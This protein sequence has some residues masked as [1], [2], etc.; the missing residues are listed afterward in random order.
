MPF[1]W[2]LCQIDNNI[3]VTHTVLSEHNSIQLTMHFTESTKINTYDCLYVH[4][5]MTTLANN[6]AQ[7]E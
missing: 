4:V 3:T 2:Y 6:F 5:T 1:L 7:N